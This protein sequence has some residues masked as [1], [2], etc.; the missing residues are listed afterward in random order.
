LIFYKESFGAR[1]CV[2]DFYEVD[3]KW[4]SLT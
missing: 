2:H 3:V 1:A 4:K